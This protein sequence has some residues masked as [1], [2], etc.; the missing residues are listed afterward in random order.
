MRSAAK[1]S[2]RNF[3]MTS[4]A[5]T[6]WASGTA[7]GY[8]G[9][10]MRA[11]AAAGDLTGVSKWDLDTPAL[12]VDLDKL[13]QNIAAMRKSLTAVKVASRPHAKTH[14]CPAIAKLQL[15]GGSIGICTA[16]VS[17]AEV[18]SAS[19]VESILM[20][21][22]NVT[23]NKIRR[24]MAIRKANPHF[25]Q[26]V[27]YPQNAL[28]LNDAAKEAGV[29]AA[30][31]VIDVAVGTRSGVPAGD[32]AVGLAKLVDKLPYLK[33][34]GVISYDG[35][36]QHIKGFKNRLDQTLK[37]FEPSIETLEKMHRA[38]LTTEI[39]SG[40]GTGTYNILP[41]APGVTDVQVGSYIFM[42]CQYLEIGG[43]SNDDVYADF[44]PSLTVLA[45]VLNT[46]F[47]KSITTDAGA[48]ALT[49]NKPGP[50]VIGEKDFVYNAG[51][52]EFGVIK[53]EKA[54]R[55]YKVGDKLELIV[56]HCDPA[57]NEYDQL[58]A[59]RNDRVEAVWPIAARGHSQ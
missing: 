53:Y 15:A 5:A 28:D 36:A 42:D 40:G 46:Y 17:E 51:S 45:T 7:R 6:V 3:L 1:M 39:F 22:S 8:T 52:D 43:E 41:K 34:R 55:S 57:V 56:P 32:Q 58:Y 54:E 18:F 47:E 27:D 26:A 11:R 9:A 48:K 59:I 38:G 19:G 35:G 49:L 16:K 29:S 50:W 13:E 14:K 25:I 10:E 2:R 30:D 12:C 4:G 21:T 31:V 44:V 37:R 33:L 20:T 23:P 24:A